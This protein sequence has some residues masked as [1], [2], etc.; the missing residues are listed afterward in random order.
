MSDYLESLFSLNGK[1]ALVTGGGKGIGRM[2]AESLLQAGARVYISSRS[3]E[4]C[5]AAAAE[6]A[7]LGDCRAYPYDLSQLNNIEALAGEI[8]A[9]GQGLHILVNNSGAT[10][11]APLDE[12]PEAGWD[13]VMN[14]NVKSPFFLIQKLL[15]LLRAAGT[16]E[17]PARVINISSVAATMAGSQSAYSYM[18]SKAAISHLTRGLAVDLAK[19]HIA[20][21]SIAPGFF[22]SKMTSHMTTDEGLAFMRSLAPMGRIGEPQDIAGVMLLL[23]G[24]AGSFMTGATIPI[25]GGMDLGAGY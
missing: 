12:F 25:A 3:A 9:A 8:E 20:V 15:P 14:L 16:Q 10:W 17:D 2:I 5:E 21:N 1:T 19:Q 11:G 24:A 18:A 6:M 7:A 23:C 4:D 22:P 13:K